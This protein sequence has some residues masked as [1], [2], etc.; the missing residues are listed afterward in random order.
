M[1]RIAGQMVTIFDTALAEIAAATAARF[2]LN[3]RDVL[4]LMRTEFRAIRTRA[5][6]AR[7]EVAEALPVLV[8]DEAARRVGRGLMGVPLANTQR[9]AMEAMAVALEPPAPIDLLTWAQE[10]VVFDDGPFQGPYNRRLFPFF[11]EILRALSPDDP[12]RYVTLVSSAQC[13]K[14]SLGNIFALASMVLNRGTA[15]VAHPTEDNARRWSR[16]KL[17]PMMRSIAVVREAFPQRSRDSADAVFFKERRDG[18]ACLLITGANSPASL[19]QVTIGN[20]VLDDLAKWEPNSAGDPEAM[21][22]SRARAIADAKIFKI[23]TPLITPGCRITRNFLDGSQETP[24]VP[25][26]HCG[27]T[28]V[29]EWDNMLAG[30][31]EARPEDAHFTCVACGAVIEEHHRPQMLAGF[32]WRAQNPAAKSYHRSFTIWSAYS[33]LQSWEQIAREWLRAKGNPA[34]EK[35]FF[36]DVLGKPYETRGDGRPWEELRDRAAK[37]HYQRGTVPRG[38]LLLMLGV[39]CQLDRV[40]WQVVGFGEHYRRYVVDYGTIGK[41]IAEPDC[42][43]NLDKLLDRK[44]PNF[45][46]REMGI[47]CAAI[48]AGYATDDVLRYAPALFAAQAHCGARCPGRPRSAHREGPSRAQREARHD[49]EVRREILQHRSEHIEDVAVSRLDEG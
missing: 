6:V 41:S 36:N 16:I 21:A 29:L 14:T 37:S 19:S 40:E 11:D 47:T 15:L 46:G 30:L 9:L 49:S 18:L 25:C 28:Q 17:A 34:S 42:Q 26:P 24:F 8:E 35:T 27:H 38:G 2:A 23:S 44:W 5:A 13:G 43:R 31:D 3:Q 4:H 45:C 12:C 22:E 32:E 10:H 1:G 48:D 39:D 20:M 7:R 33:P